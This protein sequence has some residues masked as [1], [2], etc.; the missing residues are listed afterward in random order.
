MER[1]DR[2]RKVLH[3][4]VKG[5]LAEGDPEIQTAYDSLLK[6]G[7]SKIQ[8]MDELSSA[9]ICVLSEVWTKKIPESEQATRLSMVLIRLAE[10]TTVD[11]IW[12]E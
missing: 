9:V 11:E 3:E 7:L 2:R 4:I 5:M 8:V 10:G 6:R 12:P 1:I